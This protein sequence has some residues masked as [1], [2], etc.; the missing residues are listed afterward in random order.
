MYMK[1]STVKEP[2]RDRRARVVYKTYKQ[3]ISKVKNELSKRY[4]VSAVTIFRWI[5]KGGKLSLKD[6]QEVL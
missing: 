5:Q 2:I 3:E 1:K 6:A 4:G